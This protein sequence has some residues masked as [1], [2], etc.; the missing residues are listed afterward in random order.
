MARAYGGN[1]R[2]DDTY[3]KDMLS[4]YLPDHSAVGDA[5]RLGKSG[6][7]GRRAVLVFGFD[8]AD[9]PLGPAIEALE[10]GSSRARGWC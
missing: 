6:F 5:V 8:Y 1:G 4:P 9:R 2:L 3:L 7:R 10:P